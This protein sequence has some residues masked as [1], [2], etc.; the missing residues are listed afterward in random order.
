MTRMALERNRVTIAALLIVVVGGISAYLSLPQNEDP[1][2]TIRT[3]LVITYFPGAGPERVESLVTDK[4]EEAIQEI[5]ELDSVTSES[6]TGVSIVFV[7]ISERYDEMRPIW[8]QL[9]RKVDR[10]SAS[11]PDGVIGP[12]VNDEFGDV[13]GILL[14]LTGE[15]LSLRQLEDVADE[16]RRE[17]LRLPEAAKVQIWGGQE[18]RIF[19]EYDDARL[20]EVGLSA[21]QLKQILSARNIVIP[22]GNVL[23]GQ[24]R[25][26]LEPS[27]NYE[28]I[29]DLGMTVITL[30][31]RSDL[32]YLR[33]VAEI[34]RAY[35]DPP[36]AL[37]R[38]DGTPALVLGVALREGGSILRL[39][40]SV[41]ERLRDFRARYP[42]GVE[43][44]VAA[45]QPAR[46]EAKID[47]FVG[48]LIQAIAIV[49]LVMLIFLGLRTGLV[50]ASL[51]PMAMLL[52]LLVM[53]AIGVGLDQMSLAALIIALGMLID[54][55][56]VVSESV[57]VQMGQ[58]ASPF[59]AAVATGDEMRIPLLTSSL[60]T[61]AAFLPF[62][63]AKSTSGEYT[64][65]I[66]VVVSIALLS[67]WV[68]SLTMTPLLCVGFLPK[69][70][71]VK[72]EEGALT[73]GYGRSLEMLLAHRWL[74]LL[75]VAAMFAA[76]IA[77]FPFIPKLFFP[78]GDRT[79]F[80]VQLRAPTGTAIEETDRI[81]SELD[82]LLRDERARG[83]DAGVRSWVSFVGGGEPRYI[84]NANV[85]QR[86]SAYSFF[87]VN[88]GAWTEV[89][90][91]MDRVRAFCR[92]RF[93][94][95]IATVNASELGPPVKKPIQVRL[96]G[97]DPDTLFE[98]VDQVK[99][100][101]R[102][103]PGARGVNDDWGRRTKKLFVDV[104][105]PRARHA[106]VSSQDVAISLQATL[107]GIETTQYRE[108][109]QIIPITL[110]SSAADRND[111]GKLEA[112]Y[113]YS[114]A[115][116]AAVPLK[117]VAD[118]E[119]RWEASKIVRRNRVKTVTVE[120]DTAAGVTAS[121]V[122]AGL[123][124]WLQDQ[125]RYWPPGYDVELGG[126]IES[127]AK[128]QKSIADQ[129]PVAGL[130]ILLLLV[131]QF[132]SF[133]RPAIILAT[134]PLG[135]IGVIA[136]LIAFRSYFGFMTLLGIVS[137]AGIVIN[138]AIVLLDRIRIEREENGLGAHEAIL[139]ASKRRLRPILLTTLTTVGGLVPLYLGGGPMWEPMAVAI[140]CG[141]AFA[142]L[143]T[144]GLV[145]ILYALLFRVPPA[146]PVS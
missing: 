34:T 138:N 53:R 104:S 25:I 107:S 145:P 112:L 28:T 52:T 113:V 24:E 40:K 16:A 54:N 67:S 111:L 64:G 99:A 122:N 13:F 50:V 73:R 117:Q 106:G 68:L 91:I 62:F 79:F 20:A 82:S 100:E 38:A 71:S 120:S 103:I 63:L 94:D 18:E 7:N 116:G 115:T 95:V 87:L 136:G 146:N 144:L 74:V 39:G 83:G 37:V 124:P 121:D 70:P 56:I 46:V 49:V 80:T 90:P 88:T 23:V 31:G 8:D 102:S 22:G 129:L 110:R 55:A 125:S 86:N 9:R 130:A 41:R 128:A 141:L 26:A 33:D 131:G 75:G 114:Q 92:D 78:R 17:L 135:L 69:A 96:S 19:V 137:L 97:D 59:D 61:A 27:G 48:N 5:P 43:F 76:A 35:V 44:G 84:L 139:T 101:L 108:G 98:L 14:T 45:F 36:A 105:Q 123:I 3:A 65:V 109:N 118:M 42:I 6:R 15:G 29:E 132:N 126:E 10:V 1:G 77:V 127:S 51:I 60:T 72:E 143:L 66:F 4:V 133:R 57:M 2:F 30:P 58:G 85:E 142:T 134:I 140:M 119:V 47:D 12:T 32:V 21:G 89:A 81:A 11:L 93:P